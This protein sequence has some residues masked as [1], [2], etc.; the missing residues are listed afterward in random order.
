MTRPLRPEEI[1]GPG[2][3][4]AAGDADALAIA[5]LLERAVAA[6]DVRPTTDFNARL[7][8]AVALEAAPR[9]SYRL[10]VGGAILSAWQTA[11]GANYPPLMRA[12]AVALLLIVALVIGSLG[13]AATLAAA[14]AIQLFEPHPSS[15]PV[16]T[17]APPPQASPLP[18]QA[19][20]PG[21]T[22]EPGET[23]EPSE[24]VEPSETP[25]PTASDDHGG[26]GGGGSGGG[27]GSG[28]GKA[29]P[30]PTRTPWPADTPEP[31]ETP[32]PSD[33]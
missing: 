5:R 12:R 22:Q 4:G 33:N 20:G 6:D 28:S 14:G 31:T 25:E 24:T 29:T 11:L 7:M 1:D 32:E 10:L 23:P 9:R 30:R 3:G 17:P 27:D 19:P 26:G 15:G 8:A 18:S 13:G 2:G 21:I 16:V